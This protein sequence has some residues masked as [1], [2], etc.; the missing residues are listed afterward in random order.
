MTSL[1]ASSSVRSADRTSGFTQDE[2]SRHTSVVKDVIIVVPFIVLL[3]VV[4]ANAPFLVEEAHITE[5]SCLVAWVKLPRPEG[6]L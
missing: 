1:I 5:V 6:Q 3:L 2:K 4:Y